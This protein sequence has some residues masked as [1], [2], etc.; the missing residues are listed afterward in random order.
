MCSYAGSD[1]LALRS[2]RESIQVCHSNG[3]VSA[4]RFVD[5]LISDHVES[6]AEVMWCKLPFLIRTPPSTISIALLAE[7]LLLVCF[8]VN[9]RLVV[10]DIKDKIS[11]LGWKDWETRNTWRVWG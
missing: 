1:A 11:S 8:S 3:H 2:I 6:I 7:L 4:W 9:N 10:A 5:W